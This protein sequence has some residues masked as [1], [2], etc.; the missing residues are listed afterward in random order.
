MLLVVGFVPASLAAQAPVVTLDRVRAAGPLSRGAARRTVEGA[1]SELRTCYGSA[2]AARADLAGT[3][4]L[5]IMVSSDGGVVAASVA[6]RSFEHG[7][8]ERCVSHA[9]MALRFTARDAGFTTVRLTVRFGRARVRRSELQAT[10]EGAMGGADLFSMDASGAAAAFGEGR[11]RDGR[12]AVQ[13]AGLSVEV[14]RRVLRQRRRLFLYCYERELVDNASL[15]GRVEL[16][17][18][19][20]ARGRVQTAMV[21]G[22]TLGSAIDGCLVSQLRRLRFPEPEG[23]GTVQIRY[24]LTFSPA[25]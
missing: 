14:V 1:L 22:S 15:A 12:V 16:R 4:E 8:L 11:L 17:F 13:Q 2:L 9:L 19:V 24:P 5:R 18:V 7:E 23:G 10:G 3:L 6:A 21:H 25:S 20:G